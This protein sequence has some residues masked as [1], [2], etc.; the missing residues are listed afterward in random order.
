MKKIALLFTLIILFSCQKSKMK[1]QTATS[2]YVG[3]YTNGESK[4]IYTY[5]LSKE[6]KFK[7]IGLAAETSNPSFLAKSND[8]KTLFAVDEA[9]E[10]GTGFVKSYSIENDSLIFISKSKSGG[11]HPCFISVNDENQVLVANYSGGN[12]GLLQV[13]TS[14][15]LSP[16]LNIQQHKGM[17]TTDRQK[18]PHAHSSWF[19]PTKKEVISVDLGTNQL[20][21]STID[22]MKN[23]FVF[24]SQKTLQMEVGAGPRHLTFHPAKNWIYV[25]N[26]LNNT[27]SLVKEKEGN[28][29]IDNSISMLPEGYA[30]Y[31]NA[32]DIHISK[33]GQFLYASN[34]G[35]NSIVMYKVHPENGTLGLIGFEPVL[36]KN[37][38]NFSLSPDNKFLLVANQDT[39]NMVSFRRDEITGKLTFIDEIFAPNPVCILF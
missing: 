20:W 11:A 34:R 32:A 15:E 39:N 27:I 3:T 4:G 9:N 19:H 33:D 26:E 8:E 29:F 30:E 12:V 23:E 6:G 18:S 35:H 13:E 25:L 36:G 10:E 37:P 28:Y 17:G 14:G 21:F 24:T 22:T 16:L 5:E 38:R 7:Q 1:E 2:F 31:T